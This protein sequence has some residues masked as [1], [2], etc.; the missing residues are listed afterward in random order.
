MDYR[1]ET[2]LFYD[3]KQHKEDVSYALWKGIIWGAG[4]M[5]GIVLLLLLPLL[6][7]IVK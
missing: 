5:G 4:L 3:Y 1:D 6:S 7:T 2:P